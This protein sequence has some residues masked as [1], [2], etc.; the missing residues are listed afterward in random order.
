MHVEINEALKFPNGTYIFKPDGTQIDPNSEEGDLIKHILVAQDE[1]KEGNRV[2]KM[3]W[4]LST[5]PR[6]KEKQEE[7]KKKFGL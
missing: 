2:Q 7:F 4:I 6:N 5:F 3:R 1:A